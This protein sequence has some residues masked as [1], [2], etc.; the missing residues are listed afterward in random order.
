VCVC[1]CVWVCVEGCR[2]DNN[3]LPATCTHLP[4]LFTLFYFIIIFLVYAAAAAL[5]C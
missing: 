3:W 1:V 2:H 5:Y 4:V